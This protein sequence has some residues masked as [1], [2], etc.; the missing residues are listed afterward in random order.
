M[1]KTGKKIN[2]RYELRITLTD[3]WQDEDGMR[4]YDP[5]SQLNLQNVIYPST[6]QSEILSQIEYTFKEFSHYLKGGMFT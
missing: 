1:I 3:V 4:E 5:D 2:R 6:D